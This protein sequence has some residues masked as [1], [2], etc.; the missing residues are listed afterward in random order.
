MNASDNSVMR[1]TAFRRHVISVTMFT[2]FYLSTFAY[3][4]LFSDD[5]PGDPGDA[6]FNMYI[7][8]HTYQWLSG[9]SIEILSPPIFY[10]YPYSLF[11]S[12][13]HAVTSIIYAALRFIGFSEYRAFGDYIRD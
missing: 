4:F 2:A 7:L 8:E 1:L 9:R 12:D 10:P 3:R 5:V 13:T 11:F 6:R